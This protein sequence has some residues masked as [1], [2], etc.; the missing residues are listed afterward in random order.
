L[1]FVAIL[2]VLLIVF[3]V[4]QPHRVLPSLLPLAAVAIPVALITAYFTIPFLLYKGY[5]S[6]S[7][8]LQRW[9]YDSYGAQTILSWMLHGDLFDHSRLPVMTLLVVVGIAS[10]LSSRS[11]PA[12]LAVVMFLFWLMVYF[13]RPTWGRLAD[14]LPLHQGLLFHRFSAG[15]DLGAILL[16]GLGGDWL[17]SQ[18]LRLGAQWGQALAIGIII[19]LMLP[20]LHE[21][22]IY[23][24]TNQQWMLIAENALDSDTD[25]KEIIDTLKTLPPGRT[26]AGLKT[27]WGNSIGWGD[28]RFFD[29]LTFYQIP[30]VSP[31]YQSLSLNSDLIWH[32][33]DSNAADYS[34]FN[35][36]YV[37]AP[38]RLRLTSFFTPIRK[39]IRY[40]LYRVPGGGY[41]QFV[42]IAQWKIAD[43]QQ[44][45]FTQNRAW[46]SSNDPAAASF[47]R[48]SYLGQDR[49]PGLNPWNLRGTITNEQVSPG[50]LDLIAHTQYA[51]TLIFKMTYHP[52]WHV[53][54]DLHEHPTFMVSPSFIGVTVPAGNHVVSVVYRSN[55]LKDGLLIVTIL[56]LAGVIY[57]AVRTR[58][59]FFP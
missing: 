44:N 23:Y 32:F 40:T 27:D 9:K 55:R 48:W 22:Y 1:T 28:L 50:R 6:A 45:L 20:A 25:A 15:V 52:D 51:A 57:G 58:P 13:G 33:H 49:G 4:Q 46:M 11:Q 2:A 38:A 12:I 29:L 5:L 39:T 16:V 14:L 17:W 59:G 26:Y 19:L 41:A 47:I 54:I 30:A 56:T 8:Y 36:M 42:Q 24:S 7:P 31:P 43:S 3:T 35:V 37:V 34:L 21:R 53:L 10:A 18:C